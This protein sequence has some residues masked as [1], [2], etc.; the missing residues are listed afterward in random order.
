MQAEIEEVVRQPCKKEPIDIPLKKVKYYDENYMFDYQY[1]LL[2]PRYRQ[3]HGFRPWT[4]LLPPQ[5]LPG[6]V[7]HLSHLPYGISLPYLSQEP[8]VLQNPERVV[9]LSECERFEQ[10]YQPN[11]ALAPRGGA[12]NGA[13]TPADRKELEKELECED[14]RPTDGADVKIKKERPQTPPEDSVSPDLRAESPPPPAAGAGTAS[15]SPEESGSS[16]EITSSTSPVPAT[17]TTKPADPAVHSSKTPPRPADNS[18]IHHLMLRSHHLAKAAAAALLPPRDP[19]ALMPLTNGAYYHHKANGLATNSELELSTDTDDDSL[20]GEA[21]SSNNIATLDIAIEALKDTRQQERD[22]VLAIIKALLSE[23][24]QMNMKNA[25]LRQ[26]LRRKDDE[27]ADLLQLQRKCHNGSTNSSNCSS[28]NA[29]EA[30]PPQPAPKA[31]EPPPPPP[32]PVVEGK[33]SPEKTPAADVVAAAPAAEPRRK[34][35]TDVIRVPLKKSARR[36]P[37][38]PAVVLQPP[39][40]RD[41]ARDKHNRFAEQSTKAP[42]PTPIR[43]SDAAATANEAA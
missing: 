22:K 43:E 36:S 30:T 35:E 10:S 19:D 18:H 29:S 21:D 20:A 23:N 33:Q 40:L 42:S 15:V 1:P 39:K 26:E 6:S 17:T 14:E 2:F 41:E 34:S 38:E 3:Y 8:P 12:K 37:E 9:R 11:V 7:K 5:S 24:I 13:A 32:P 16:N 25:K 31:A 4:Q 27:I 28:N